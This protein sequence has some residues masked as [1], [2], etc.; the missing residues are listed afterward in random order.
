MVQ[1]RYL[2]RSGVERAPQGTSGD[3]RLSEQRPR[4]RETSAV[5]LEHA[6]QQEWLHT[7]CWGGARCVEE[8]M[9]E[10]ECGKVHWVGG[11]ERCGNDDQVDLRWYA[12]YYC[13]F[14]AAAMLA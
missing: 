2:R 4:Q 13:P 8:P 6:G 7:H 14:H 3:E 10:S 11:Q 12:G 5:P 1:P 9:N